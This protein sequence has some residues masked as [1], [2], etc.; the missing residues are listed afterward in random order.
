MQHPDFT[1]RR[2]LHRMQPGEN[3]GLRKSSLEMWNN[4]TYINHLEIECIDTSM[5]THSSIR[6]QGCQTQHLASLI[7]S[8]A[9]AD[10]LQ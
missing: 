3:V 9:C 6:G 8:F 2:V 1:P 5:F 7:A 4:R 10:P